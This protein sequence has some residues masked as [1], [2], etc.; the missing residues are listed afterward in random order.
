MLMG[1]IMIIQFFIAHPVSTKANEHI[2][3][4]AIVVSAFSIILGIGSLIDH[5]ADRVKRK[6]EG[7][8]YS[9]VALF[10]LV[11]MAL[12][13]LFGGIK[14]GTIFMTIYSN[15]ILPL[16]ASMFAIL[17]FY[18]ASAAY[19]AFRARTFEATL[20]LLAAFIVMLG[21]VPFGYFIHPKISEVAEWLLKVPNTAAKR[22]IMFGVALG[23]VST[24]LKIILGIERSWLGGGGK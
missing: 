20:L 16:G 11:V 18:M 17:A 19:R 21:F 1:F 7:W 9:I 4:W 6:N 5:H 8:Q 2:S 10:S 15:V 14:S 3:N 23:V 24:S 13:G 12:I 22:G